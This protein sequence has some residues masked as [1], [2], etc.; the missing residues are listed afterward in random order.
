MGIAIFFL[1]VGIISSFRGYHDVF[2]HDPT[3]S[4]TFEGFCLISI[5]ETN[6][7]LKIG[8]VCHCITAWE[9]IGRAQ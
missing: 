8:A 4:E 9:G 1:S 3:D 7:Y 5:A 6:E 2:M